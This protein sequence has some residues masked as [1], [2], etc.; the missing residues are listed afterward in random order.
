MVPILTV[1]QALI[2]IMLKCPLWPALYTVLLDFAS[3]LRAE[4]IRATRSKG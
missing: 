3:V 4:R 1:L 2:E